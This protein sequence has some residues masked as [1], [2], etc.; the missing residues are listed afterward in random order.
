M[1]ITLDEIS[2]IARLAHLELDH[3]EVTALQGDLDRILQHVDKLGGLD[4][5]GIDPA[6]GSADLLHEVLR[7]DL[8]KPTLTR[9]EALA[10]APET[11]GGHFKVPKIIT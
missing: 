5:E 3:E 1:R 6:G 10:N 7:P 2:H 9:E 8:P 11:S 4:T